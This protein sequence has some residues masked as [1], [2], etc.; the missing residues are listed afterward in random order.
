MVPSIA[1]E[2]YRYLKHELTRSSA[3]TSWKQSSILQLQARVKTAQRQ[4]VENQSVKCES[5]LEELC[6]GLQRHDAVDAIEQA[7][8]KPLRPLRT[9]PTF[10]IS[11]SRGG[12]SP[13]FE[14]DPFPS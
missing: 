10:S 12:S 14:P 3:N 8:R 2:Q 7:A 5:E 4:L 6:R 9:R 1:T 13:Y 11:T